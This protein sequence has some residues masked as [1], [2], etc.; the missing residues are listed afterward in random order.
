MSSSSKEAKLKISISNKSTQ[1]EIKPSR[2][3]KLKQ[4]YRKASQHASTDLG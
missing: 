1:F 2:Y 3:P 4:V